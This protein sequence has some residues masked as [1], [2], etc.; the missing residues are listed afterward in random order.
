M[1]AP[2]LHLVPVRSR[3][4][5][6]FVPAWHRHPPPAG[7]VFAVG[8]ADEEGTLRAVATVG[9]PVAQY[10]DDGQTLEVTRTCND[11]AHNAN[12]MLYGAAWRAAKAL[13]YRRLITYTQEGESGALLRGAG[14]RVIARRPPRPGPAS[15]AAPSASPAFCGKP[16]CRNPETSPLYEPHDLDEPALHP[17][18]EDARAHPI[19]SS[20]SGLFTHFHHIR[21]PNGAR[22]AAWVDGPSDAPVTAV[23]VHGLSVTSALWRSHVPLLLG[24]GMQVVRYDQRAHGHSTRGTAALGLNQLADDLAHILRTTAPRGHLV[25]VGH[26]M[27]AMTLTRLV[28]RH[29]ELAPRIHRLVL[30]SPPYAG[31]STRTGTG[32]LRA[33]LAVGRN[34]LASACS[35]AP[36]VLDTARRRLPSTSRW[37]LR[38]H[39]PTASDARPLPCR[40]G[41]HAMPTRDI[42][43]LWHDLADQ[44]PDP[45]PL[46]QLGDRV[47]L[48][49][50]D[51]D[52]HIPPEQTRRLAASLPHAGLEIVSDASH[53]L[54]LRHAQLVT[55]RITR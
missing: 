51:R 29:P 8:A 9:R 30:I 6:A 25:L 43:A 44:Q 23:L 3:D 15:R 45:G 53:A 52:T 14:W 11:G 31:V 20:P 7:Q 38:S 16:P 50:G 18:I 27:G 24:R 10:L 41:L 47:H 35:R 22:V 36:Q 34:L 40:H 19:T 28:A 13:G 42:A 17:A 33:L 21:L 4:A 48:L 39:T 1:S 37:A 55:D 2:R 54:P 32:P 26:S 12:S 46:H 5:K 49:A